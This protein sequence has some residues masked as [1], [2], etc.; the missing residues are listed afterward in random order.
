M[1][2]GQNEKDFA[3]HMILEFFKR[4]L[5]DSDFA[6]LDR[7]LEFLEKA[8]KTTKLSESNGKNIQQLVNLLEK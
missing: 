3:A 2:M 1:N 6:E 4:G 7:L 8:S 5:D